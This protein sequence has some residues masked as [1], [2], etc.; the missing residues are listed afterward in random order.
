ME[1]RYEPPMED[2]REVLGKG[3]VSLSTATVPQPLLG[4]YLPVNPVQR[5][6]FKKW[7]PDDWNRN[8]ETKRFQSNRDRDASRVLRSEAKELIASST[9]KSNRTQTEVT[10]RLGERVQSISYWKFE[11]E[12]GIQDMTSEIDLMVDEI[13]RVENA[14]QATESPMLIARDC[15]ANRQRRIDSDLV[16]DD[17]EKALLKELEI[18]TDVRDTLKR[19]LENARDQ[20]STNRDCKHQLEM[21]WSDKFSANH[22]DS[23]SVSLKNSRGNIVYKAGSAIYKEVESHPENWL[24]FSQ[25]NL[26]RSEQEREASMRLR[27]SMAATL[28]RT[29]QDMREQADRVEGA[30]NRRVAETEEAARH[31]ETELKEIDRG[32]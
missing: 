1:R 15:L 21:D 3:T 6:T 18:I 4:S 5:Y 26:R 16:Q 19:T 13:R 7:A 10:E 8:I 20:Q 25:A 29:S 28:S 14:I 30:L 22:L 17:A 2:E 31:L 32:G 27:G 12:R 11:L 24:E 23:K 9:T